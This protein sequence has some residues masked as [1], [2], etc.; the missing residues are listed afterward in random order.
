[1]QQLEVIP[2]DAVLRVRPDREEQDL[3]SHLVR[4]IEDRS[5]RNRLGVAARRYIEEN[6]RNEQ[7]I[8]KYTGLIELAL[9]RKQDFR[10]PELPLHLRS[11]KEIMREYMNR[12]GFQGASSHL[13]EQS[14]NHLPYCSSSSGSSLSEV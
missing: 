2:V 5:L 1:L 3:F 14:L 4:L 8:E 7:V 9:T 6:H 12:S 11:G 10:S 13:L